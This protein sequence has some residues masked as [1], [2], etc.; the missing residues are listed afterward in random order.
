LRSSVGVA[1]PEF[2]QE[3]AAAAW[4]DDAHAAERRE[5]FS[6]KR[7]VLRDSFESAGLEVIGSDAGLYL[8]IKV[9]DDMAATKR[10]LGEGV[11]VSP[12]RAFGTGGE[13]HIRLALV[14]TID[15]CAAAVEVVIRCLSTKN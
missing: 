2:V 6:A 13:G 1:S 12:G 15:E 9:E 4:S 7:R 11:V 5:I 10:L 3:A 8:W 14:P